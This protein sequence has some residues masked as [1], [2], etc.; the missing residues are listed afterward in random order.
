MTREAEIL[1]GAESIRVFRLEGCR[2]RKKI[3]DPD[4]VRE[5]NKLWVE[6]YLRRVQL[7]QRKPKQ[8]D[9]VYEVQVRDPALYEK[10]FHEELGK[11]VCR[12]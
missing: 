8:K 6:Q 2:A 5:I 10:L 4:D 1:C 9:R 12:S 11:A 7:N 3:M